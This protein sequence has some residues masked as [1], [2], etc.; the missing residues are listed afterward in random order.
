LKTALS[1]LTLFFFDY[2]HLEEK[3]RKKEKTKQPM[4]NGQPR[5][6]KTNKNK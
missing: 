6:E 2:F 4:Q 1:I 3:E 5:K